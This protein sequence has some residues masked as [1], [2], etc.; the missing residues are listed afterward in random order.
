VKGRTRAVVLASTCLVAGLVLNAEPVVLRDIAGGGGPVRL[1]VGAVRAPL[2]SAAFAQEA[3]SFTLENLTVALESATFTM[4]SMRFSGVTSTR[5]EI[6]ALFSPG[7]TDPL[8]TRLAKIKAK[9]IVIPEIAFEM[10]GALAQ[11]GA[12]RDVV[13]TDVA[14]GRV[15]KAVIQSATAETETPAASASA[16]YGRMVA[17]DMDVAGMAK[18]YAEG[19][20]QGTAAPILLQRSF[21]SEGISVKDSRGITMKVARGSGRDLRMR[22]GSEPLYEIL[23]LAAEQE[24]NSQPSEEAVR[25]MLTACLEMLTGAEFGAFELTGLEFAGP[26]EKP[27][28]IGRVARMAYLGR[29]ADRPA[30]LRLEGFEVKAADGMAKIDLLSF[31]GFSFD[32]TFAA[33]GRLKEKPI[34]EGTNLDP[35]TLRALIPTIGT[36]RYAGI[37]FDVPNE[38]A[39]GQNPERVKFSAKDVELTADKPINGVPTNVRLG[40]QNLAMPLPANSDE[41]GIRELLGMGYKAIDVSWRIA[42]A[43]SEQAREIGFSE[44][45]F[46]GVD[47]G[48][49]SAKAV[50]GGVGREAFDPDSMMAMVALFGATAKSFDLTFDNAGLVDRLIERQAREQNKSP[51]AMRRELAVAATAMVPAM[52]GPSDQTR[53][54][55]QAIARFVAKPVRLR[56]SAKAKNP[57]GIGFNDIAGADTPGRFLSKVDLKAVA[58]DKF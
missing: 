52:L 24:Q 13:L 15:G 10:R 14:D 31:T 1:T 51:E 34:D 8:S 27:P 42:A 5:A 17:E 7:A 23:K 11:R 43:W 58:E 37:A 16:V 3:G 54:L 21:S 57:A 12:Y 25:R 35:A 41:D 30:D 40:V 19:S 33:L 53:A 6:D 46:N 18:I 22:P 4:K 9:E 38:K 32:T 55:G 44:I 47:M 28:I 20:G 36:I 45:S 2:W 48:R 26:S 50:F 39:I 56:I 49:L 29:T